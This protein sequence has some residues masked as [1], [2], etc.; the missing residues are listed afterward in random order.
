[1]AFLCSETQFPMNFVLIIMENQEKEYVGTLP[2]ITE[3]TA[4]RIQM[5][6]S[7]KTG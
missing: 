6:A 2:T 7:G 4:I 3:M 5:T 1:M